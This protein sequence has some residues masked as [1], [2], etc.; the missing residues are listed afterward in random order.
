MYKGRFILS[1]ITSCPDE[2]E[3]TI[4]ELVNHSFKNLFL[5]REFK[6][7]NEREYSD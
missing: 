7:C 6:F 1:F 2:Q 3:M 4:I 5:F